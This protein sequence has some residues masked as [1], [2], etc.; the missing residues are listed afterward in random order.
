[1]FNKVCTKNLS[2]LSFTEKVYRCF[3][4]LWMWKSP[5]LAEDMWNMLYTAHALYIC[6]FLEASKVMITSELF[7]PHPIFSWK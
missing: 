5:L 1:M 6:Y 3:C 4:M 2:Y 7:H